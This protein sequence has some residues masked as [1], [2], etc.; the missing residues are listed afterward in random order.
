M[1]RFKRFT[2]AL[3]SGYVVLAATVLFKLASIPLANAYLPDKEFGLWVLAM[4]ING[5]IQLVDFGMS[6]SVSRILID[7]KDRRA[8]GEF[9]GV[10]KTAAL[11]GM[12]QGVVVLLAGVSLS[13]FVGGLLDDDSKYLERDFAWLMAGQ[14][15]IL[16]VSFSAR[17]FSLLLAAHQRLDISNY[18]QTVLFAVNYA[19]MWICFAKGFGVFSLLIAQ[20]VGTMAMIVVNGT[21][22]V[23]LKLFPASGEWGRATWLQFKEFFMFGKDVFLYSL[24]AQ[25]VNTSQAIILAP[26]FGLEVA[27]VWNVC[28]QAYQVLNQFASRV[29]DYST[30]TLAEMIVRGERELL[31]KRFHE[32]VVVTAS[33]TVATGAV[34]AVCNT[35]FVHVWLHGKE[36]INQIKISWMPLDDLLLAVWLIVNTAAR[37]HI[38]LV[39]QTK[40]FRLL[41]LIYF[42]EGVVFITVTLLFDG[43]GGI[44][45]M[46][47]VSI[48]C[49][50][51]FS[52][53]YGLWR[54]RDY[55]KLRWREL[56]G[57]YHS[58][59]ALALWV[60]PAT[61]LAWWVTKDFLPLKQMLMGAAI[62]APWSAWMFLRHGL[63]KPLQIELMRRAPDWAKPALELIGLPK[64]TN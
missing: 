38:G 64:T 43:Y 30:A 26:I 54:T 18:A 21:G 25:L 8:S 6:G 12:V 47:L 55:F 14:C 17:I 20:I 22:C 27:A 15:A 29:F 62:V 39:G 56:A 19:V 13:F 50:L 32:I 5:Y 34:F 37:M 23:R 16:A 48:A 44:G 36:I 3:L 7:Y 58:P 45:L 42:L 28:T 11:V 57:W 9:G 46:I 60:A 53:P 41:R 63:G 24:G 61:A 35:S 31:Q 2:H 10:I 49:S 40:N 59:A 52:L 1:S 51:S 33:L 4:T